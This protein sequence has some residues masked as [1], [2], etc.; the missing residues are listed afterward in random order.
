MAEI[1][2][3]ADK[4][5]K[6]T[7]MTSFEKWRNYFAAAVAGM[8]VLFGV[9]K[10]PIVNESTKIAESVAVVKNLSPVEM[11]ALQA[12]QIESL[13]SSLESFKT[14]IKEII[15]DDSTRTNARLDKHALEIEEQGKAISRLEV[16]VPRARVTN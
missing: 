15:K 5:R 4:T 8:S 10:A 9:Q 2:V 14:D 16:L 3:P 7:T 1:E 11:A 12:V 13:K 6:L